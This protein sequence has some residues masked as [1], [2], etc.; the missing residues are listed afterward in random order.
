MHTSAVGAH[1]HMT[2]V[3]VHATG[4]CPFLITEGSAIFNKWILLRSLLNSAFA[5]GVYYVHKNFPDRSIA[6]IDS[7]YFNVI[8][9]CL[10]FMLV[11]KS[12]IAYQRFWE[13][14]SRVGSCVNHTRCLLRLLI[15]GMHLQQHDIVAERGVRSIAR[16]L[17]AFFYLAV[18]D[19]HLAQVWQ[20]AGLAATWQDR[21]TQRQ[22]RL[23]PTPLCAPRRR[24][25][26]RYRST[27]C[28]RARRRG[29][30]PSAGAR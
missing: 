24:T 26:L 8:G 20:L 1:H 27:C 11:F 23:A 19:V 25:S 28:R 29:S 7:F 6:D 10:S 30:C 21:R 15:F 17:Q 14:R 9:A 5:T 3:N 12:N 13:A 18:Q 22:P 16:H 4:A 2:G